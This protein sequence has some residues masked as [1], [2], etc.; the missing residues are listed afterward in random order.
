MDQALALVEHDPVVWVNQIEG[1][2]AEKLVDVLVAEEVKE[3]RI[4]VGDELVARDEHGF[5]RRFDQ[6]AE[7]RFRAPQSFVGAFSFRDVT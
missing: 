5:G 7:E 1:A 3:A 6:L 4:D 2:S